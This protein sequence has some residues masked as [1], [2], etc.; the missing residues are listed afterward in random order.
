M[1][2]E[3]LIMLKKTIKQLLINVEKEIQSEA[4]ILL[5]WALGKDR[6]FILTHPEYIVDWRTAYRY[7]WLLIKRAYGIPLAYI[8]GHKEFFNLD[9]SV[10]RHTLIPRPETEILVEAALEIINQQH[11]NDSEPKTLLID[12]GTGTG[13][14][15][16][17]IVKNSK[18]ALSVLALDISPKALISATRNAAKNNTQINFRQ[19]DLLTNLPPAVFSEHK[20]IV[21]TA[22]LPYLTQEEFYTEPSIRHEPK[23]ALVA[24]KNGLALYFQLL[25][26]LKNLPTKNQAF[27]LLCEINPAQVEPLTQAIYTSFPTAQVVTHS[28]LAGHWR[29]VSASWQS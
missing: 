8:V 1:P 14:I 12:V 9:F 26:Q 13:C 3:R 4:Q 22:N 29:V 16:I 17:S 2:L 10:T 7:Y 23:I 6:A 15:P 28:D 27:T 11:A 20:T 21:V 5:A 19:S 24:A 25:T 18:V